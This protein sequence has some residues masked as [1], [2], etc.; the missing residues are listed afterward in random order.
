MSNKEEYINYNKCI[1]TQCNCCKFYNSCF[2]Y[3]P[4]RKNESKY[5]KKLKKDKISDI[6]IFQ[7]LMYS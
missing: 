6:D 1:R 5:I 2:E 3:K 7:Q 4:K